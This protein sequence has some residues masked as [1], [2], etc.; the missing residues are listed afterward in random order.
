MK[1]K[2]SK[3]PYGKTILTLKLGKESVQILY[4][5]GRF[6][7]VL[8]KGYSL[9]DLEPCLSLKSAITAGKE[10]LDYRAKFQKKSK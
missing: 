8:S 3:N 10:V 2:V 5:N 1:M 7:S 4:F 9:T 6:E